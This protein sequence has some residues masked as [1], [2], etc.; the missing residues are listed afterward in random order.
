MLVN[1]RCSDCGYYVILD[2]DSGTVLPLQRCVLLDNRKLTVDQVEILEG[3]SDSDRIRL[4]E[5]YG[6]TIATLTCY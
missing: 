1:T 2:L 6:T 3:D 4:G 5:E